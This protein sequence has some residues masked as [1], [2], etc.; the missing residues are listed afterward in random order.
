VKIREY[1]LPV[2]KHSVVIYVQKNKN[3]VQQDKEVFISHSIDQDTELSK[4]KFSQFQN[5]F[6]DM[7][8]GQVV[9]KISKAMPKNQI[10]NNVQTTQINRLIKIEKQIVA[11]KKKEYPS[12]TFLEELKERVSNLPKSTENL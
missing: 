7:T 9:S 4:T 11:S 10:S 6:E 3:M 8:I 12:M 2:L 5:K 1:E